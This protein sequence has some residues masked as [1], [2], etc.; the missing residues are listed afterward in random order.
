MAQTPMNDSLDLQ[1]LADI[2]L[3]PALAST[4][5]DKLAE[6]QTLS[7]DSNHPI[8]PMRVVQVQRDHVLLHDGHQT[9]RA[10]ASNPLLAALQAQFDALAVGDWVLA[11]QRSPHDW[12]AVELLPRR[13]QVSRRTHDGR[14]GVQRQVLVSNV[15]TALLIMGLDHDFNLRR[16][17]RYLTLVQLAGIGAVLVLTKADGVDDDQIAQRLQAARAVLP[18]TVPCLAVDGRDAATVQH[19][20]P[21]LQAGLTLVL[22]GSSGAGKS[23][24]TNTLLAAHEGPDS[25]ESPAA[26]PLT[27]LD[28]P[29]T[30]AVREDDSRGRHTTTHRSLH[31]TPGGACIIDTPGLRALR[32]DIDS[33]DDLAGAFGDV[34]QAAA[35]CRFRDCRHQSEPGCA[36]RDAVEPQRLR[37]FHKLLREAQRD[38]RSA[39]E[40]IEQVAQWKVRHRA[41]QTRMRIKRGA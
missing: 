12:Q 41:A 10:S 35:Q 40:R 39:L 25:P 37:N 21:W 4:L 30:G 29:A 24:L 14:G 15:D 6:W 31:R 36:V 8:R 34:L 23:T 9:H 16:L 5:A 26:Q 32:L 17:E 28:A 13:S 3:S 7:D 20:A 19:L 2:G 22:L 38:S 33:R 18:M 11:R 27:S 1:A